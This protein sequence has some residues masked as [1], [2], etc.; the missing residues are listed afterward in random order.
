MGT[1]NS[2]KTQIFWEIEFLKFEQ[3]SDD[4]EHFLNFTQNVQNRDFRHKNDRISTTTSKKFMF[5]HS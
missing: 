3:I 2:N 4:F 5:Q 1:G